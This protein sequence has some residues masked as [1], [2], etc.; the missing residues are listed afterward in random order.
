MIKRMLSM[1]MAL[2]IVVSLGQSAIGS[3]NDLPTIELKGLKLKGTAISGVFEPIAIIEDADTGQNYW[4]K[5]GDTLSNGCITQIHRGAIVLKLKGREYIFGLPAGSIEGAGIALSSGKGTGESIAVGK[6]IGNNIWT[7]K[8]D[9]AIGMLTR[10]QTIMEQARVKPYFAI[11][12]AA[13]I[14]IDRIKDQSVIKD[15]GLE[16]G[17]II[18]G[19][20]GFGLMTPT[21]VFEAYRRYKHGRLLQLQLI[22]NEEPVTLTYN[23]V[24]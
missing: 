11:G 15:M 13:G 5:V 3:T 20:N 8:M 6:R 10:V 2:V 7:L 18:K 4:Y 17:D 12:K 22:R 16:D 19:V 24:R 9:D 23:I 14:R 1:I 21:K